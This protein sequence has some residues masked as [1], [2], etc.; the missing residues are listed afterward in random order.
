MLAILANPNR[1]WFIKTLLY[2]IINSITIDNVYSRLRSFYKSNLFKLDYIATA[3]VPLSTI[4]LS[5]AENT[6]GRGGSRGD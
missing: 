6:R 4:P 3:T 5:N 1:S 2:L